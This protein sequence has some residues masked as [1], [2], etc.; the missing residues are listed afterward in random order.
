MRTLTTSRTDH[1]EARDRGAVLVLFALL[2]V[3]LLG[4]GALVIDIGA[5]YAE[6]RQLQNGADAGALAVAQDCA[7][8]D[9]ANATGTAKQ[10]ADLNAKDDVSAVDLLCGVGPGLAPCADPPPAGASSASGWVRVR[11]R[12]ET[13]DGGDQVSFVLAP[14]MNAMTGATVRATAVAAWGPLG[15][16]STLPFTISDCI[17]SAFGGDLDPDDPVIPTGI[18]TLY[19][20]ASTGGGQGGGQ[21]GEALPYELC[22]TEPGGGTASGNFGWLEHDVECISEVDAQ[23]TVGGDTGNS[24]VAKC[25]SRFPQIGD[26]VVLPVY[27]TV[28]GSGTNAVYSIVGFVGFQLTGYDVPAWGKAGGV[29]CAGNEWCI[30]GAFESVVT[31]G[32]FGTGVDFGA[33]AIKMVG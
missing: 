22:G 1:D 33:R 19:S 3:A 9:C 14:I 7:G 31:G 32:D 6:R 24:V 12:T 16:A 15:S 4:I 13:P 29:N 20:K 2:I 17:F 18:V 25:R 30:Q 10:Y 21:G 28:S 23:S 5:L 27:S 26:V 8:G 11:T